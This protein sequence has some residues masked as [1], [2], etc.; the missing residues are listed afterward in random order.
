MLKSSLCVY[1]NVYIL[2]KQTIAITRRGDKDNVLIKRESS[3][4]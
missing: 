4:N 1:S 3:D 2:V